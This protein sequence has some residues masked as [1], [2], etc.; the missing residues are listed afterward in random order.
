MVYRTELQVSV[1]DRFIISFGEWQIFFFTFFLTNDGKNK[2]RRRIFGSFL[3]IG[4]VSFEMTDLRGSG[5]K[6][7]VSI[8]IESLSYFLHLKES[9]VL[10]S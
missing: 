3:D 2:I 1:F 4:I 7:G 6:F 10:H 9:D 5:F 8:R